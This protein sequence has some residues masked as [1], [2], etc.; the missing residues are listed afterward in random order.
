MKTL[1][2]W[3]C[4]FVA[5]WMLGWYTHEHWPRTGFSAH[6]EP[7]PDPGSSHHADKTAVH[8]R[9]KSSAS[10]TADLAQPSLFEQM[11]A[12]G[13][14]QDAVELFNSSASSL[15]R[16]RYR[17]ALIQY[18]N[19]LLRGKDYVRAEQILS[20]YLDVEYRDADVLSLQATLYWSKGL[21]RRAIETL[22]EARSYEHRTPQIVLITE[23]IRKYVA[24]YARQLRASD[25]QQTQLSLYE[26]LVQVEPDHSPYFIALARTQV[27]QNRLDEARQSLFLVESDPRVSDEAQQLLDQ[28]ADTVAFSQTT[29]V[30]I[31]LVREGDHFLIEAWI[32]DALQ[33]RLLIDTGAS[34]TVIRD[35]ILRAAGVSQAATPPLRLFNTANGLVEGAVY[36]LDNLSVGE[37]SVA[38]I[39]VAALE[40][41]QLRAAEGLLGMNF[42]KHF[43]FFIDQN[44]PELRLSAHA[45]E[46]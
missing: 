8:L 25:E 12:S 29:P 3:S 13:Q 2:I 30:A 7:P 43:K 45:E 40:L 14:F 22:Y 34:M 37:Q 5:G 41:S 32:N 4:V 27:A 44:K 23:R 21:H 46:R 1:L 24:E 16:E 39:D 33:I 28:I 10:K 38:N 31:P 20:A 26:Y 15:T 9:S 17:S 19:A 35:D 36:R 11:L 42:L 18:L 6:T